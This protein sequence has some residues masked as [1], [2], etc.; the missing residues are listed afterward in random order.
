M[1]GHTDESQFSPREREVI[2]LL[3]KAKGNKQIAQA[4]G[5]SVSTVEFHLKNI[6]SK[7]G[8][9]NRVEAVKKLLKTTGGF[10]GSSTVVE[11]GKMN[12]IEDND[13]NQISKEI[14][15]TDVNRRVSLEDIVR[16]LVTHKFPVIL[17]LLLALAIGLVVY[18]SAYNKPARNGEPWSYERE[19]EYPDAATVG[20]VLERTNASD[21]MAHAQFGT[22][23]AWPPKAGYVTYEGI[24]T[25]QTDH[26]YLRLRYSKYSEASTSIQVLLDEEERTSFTPI[27]QGDWNKF[28]WSEWMDLG[29]VDRGE[30]SITFET[31]GQ[32][33]GVADLDVFVLS[34]KPPE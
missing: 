13:S 2:E 15:H 29:E 10:Q 1:A 21:D 5:I 4:L 6:F 23:P 30:H 7:L 31:E 16:Y 19:A 26:L 34:N 9:D 27:D 20:L 22:E 8:V 32:T 17:W 11:M 28:V 33:F 14:K 24:E 25:P 18:Q 3:L 12:T